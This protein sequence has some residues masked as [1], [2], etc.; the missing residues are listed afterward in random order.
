M[1]IDHTVYGTPGCSYC[2][3]RLYICIKDALYARFECFWISGAFS[4][5]YLRNIDFDRF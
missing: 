3:T 2:V 1:A 5:E 4:D